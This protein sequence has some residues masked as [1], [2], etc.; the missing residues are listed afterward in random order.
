MSCDDMMVLC[1]LADNDFFTV[2]WLL[3]AVFALAGGK[4][5]NF[6][7]FYYSLDGLKIVNLLK[8]GLMEALFD[9]FTVNFR[10]PYSLFY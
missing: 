3:A 1:R 5:R 7:T 10:L 4:G 2:S 8:R 6:F 9:A